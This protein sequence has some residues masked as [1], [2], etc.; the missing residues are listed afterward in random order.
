MALGWR[1]QYIKYKEF[2]LNI[3]SLYKQRADLRAFLEIILS[4]T[5]IIIFLVFALKPTALTIISLYN[6]IQEKQKTIAKLDQKLNALVTA[7]NL[8]K[9]NQ[10]F[11]SDIDNSVADS[12]RPDLIVQQIQA[13]SAKN[14]VAILGI[15]V[16]QVTLVGSGQPVRASENSPLPDDANQMEISLSVRGDYPNLISLLNDISNLR[17]VTKVDTAGINSSDSDQGK[18]I[19]SVITG[20]TPYLN[21]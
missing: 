7:G 12:P 15:T 10:N 16:G 4:I 8:I 9:Q 13:L 17:M 1:D 14:S 2:Y 20:R 5:T 19:V 21:K 18:V 11:I 6:E 3:Q